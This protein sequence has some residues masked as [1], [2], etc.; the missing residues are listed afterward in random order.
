MKREDRFWTVA[1]PLGWAALTAAPYVA[2]RLTAPEGW[3]YLWIL[4]PYSADSQAYLAW[5]RQA[6]LGAFLF[7]LKFTSIHHAP[8]L[9]QPFFWAVGRA[10]ALTGAEL[11]VVQLAFK[12]AG[13]VL[14]W[15]ALRRLAERLGLRGAAFRAAM[16]LA[17]FGAGLGGLALSLVG[18][19]A[20]GAHLPVDIWLVDV[21]TWWSL[22]WNPLF[23]FSLALIVFFMEALDRASDGEA[24]WEW[25]AGAALALLLLVHPYVAPLLAVLAGAAAALRRRPGILWKIAAPAAPAA[26]YV[27]WISTVNPLLAR[28]GELGRMDSPSW[29]AIALGLAP[30]LALALWGLALGRGGFLRRHALLWCWAAAALLACR[31]PAWFQRKLLFGVQLPLSLLAGAGVEAIAGRERDAKKTAAGLVA[32]AL[33]LG[34]PSWLYVADNTR[35]SLRL[36]RNGRY[37]VSKPLLEALE[38]LARDGDTEDVV[39]SSPD[40]AGLVAMITGKSAV[41][42]HWAQSVD[43]ED[44]RRWYESLLA[45]GDERAKARSLWNKVEYVVAA[46]QLK[47]EIEAPNGRLRWLKASGRLVYA[48]AEASVFVRPPPGRGPS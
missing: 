15:T 9:F 39:L 28:H 10:A 16:V 20:V 47:R 17:G 35:L 37:Y 14:F 40:D 33:A 27:A 4:P 36:H 18:M 34:A 30:A 32:I 26:A 24:G 38:F 21:N 42:G 44:S 3:S 5:A 2:A 43:A 41:W 1:W 46:G 7:K 13:V 12:C 23:P 22:T 31:A 19:D 45:P 25:R 48:N 6:Q 8:F 11:G 29:T